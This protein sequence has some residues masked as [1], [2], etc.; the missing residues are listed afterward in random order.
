MKT[1]LRNTATYG[2]GLFFLSLI[3]EGLIIQGGFNTYVIG[4]LVLC[5]LFM[6]VKPILKILSLPL[7]L[8]TLGLFSFL[9]NTIILYLATILVPQIKISSFTFSGA[10][11]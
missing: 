1:I 7:N 3:N 6:I 8:V 11:L 2:L 10:N 4:G 9:T 5:L